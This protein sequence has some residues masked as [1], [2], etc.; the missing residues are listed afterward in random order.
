MFTH[1]TALGSPPSRSGRG[2][3]IAAPAIQFN[4]VQMD[5]DAFV[6]A[7]RQLEERRD[8]SR[9]QKRRIKR[10]VRAMQYRQAALRGGGERE[11]ARRAT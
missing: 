10:E 2:W 8:I 1:R 3:C 6:I 9:K 7:D 5:R 11:R 4:G